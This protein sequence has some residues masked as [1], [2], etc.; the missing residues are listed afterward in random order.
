MH[1][2]KTSSP[3]S[4]ATTIP[5]QDKGIFHCASRVYDISVIRPAPENTESSLII[6]LRIRSVA[7]HPSTLLVLRM[8]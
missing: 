7:C 1:A 2:E 4:L 8:I 3:P 6:V 5:L